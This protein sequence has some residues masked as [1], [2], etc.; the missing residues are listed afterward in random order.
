MDTGIWNVAT[1]AAYHADR[2]CESSST[3][4]AFRA[5]RLQYHH[6]YIL[7]NRVNDSSDAM[8]L[9][10]AVDALVFPTAGQAFADL[11]AVRPAGLD[12]RKPEHKKEYAAFC[13]SNAGKTILTFDQANTAKAI[14]DA[15]LNDRLAAELIGPEHS[16]QVAIRWTDSITGIKLKA[17]YDAYRTDGVIIDLKTS[18][19][20]RPKAFNRSVEKFG[21]HVQAALYMMGREAV[22]AEEMSKPFYHL[23][24]GSSPPYAVGVYQ[25]DADWIGH[26]TTIVRQTLTDLEWC[27]QSGVWAEI[28]QGQVNLLSPGSWYNAED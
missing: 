1:N 11:F 8:I 13:E 27:R 6:E 22:F 20:P 17:K 19:D 21:Y 24:V 18:S 12:L 4:K 10:S 7:G 9:G 23:V 28:W 14:A 5:S 16:S 15:V 3:L 25:L 2:E 26:G